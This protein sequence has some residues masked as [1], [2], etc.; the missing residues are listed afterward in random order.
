MVDGTEIEVDW[1][2]L[3]ADDRALLAK[4]WT[5]VDAADTKKAAEVIQRT[6][7]DAIEKYNTQYGASVSSIRKWFRNI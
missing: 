3:D 1:S 2:V 7:N 5:S 6:I 4:D